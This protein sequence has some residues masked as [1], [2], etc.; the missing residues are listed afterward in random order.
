[1]MAAPTFSQ[2]KARVSTVRKKSSTEARFIGLSSP[3]RWT[4][5]REKRDGDLLY[6]IEQCDSPLAVRLAM[7]EDPGPNAVKV[8]VT[9]L[10][11][12]DLGDDVLIRLAKRRLIPF[13]SWRVVKTLFQAHAIDPRLAKHRWIAELLMECAARDDDRPAASGG[14]LDAET[15]WPL[16]LKHALGF[17]DG[18]PDLTSILRWSIE[19]EAAERYRATSA[20][21]KEGASSWLSEV[22][23][24]TARAVLNAIESNPKPDALPIGLA[25]GVVYHPKAAG[26][27]EKAAGKMEERHLGGTTPDERTVERWSAAANE[28]TRLQITDPRT[29]RAILDRADEILSEIGAESFAFLSSASPLGFDQR[30]A[31]FGALLSNL[32]KS[33]RY[34]AVE[35][36]VDAR[37]EVGDHENATRERVR[38][39]RLDMAIRLV[40]WLASR[41]DQTEGPAHSFVDAALDQVQ[42]AGFVDWARRAL[43]GGDSTRALSEAYAQLSDRVAVIREGQAK[44]FAEL[45]RRW[46]AEDHES[47][48]VVPVERFIED[49]ARPLAEA[50]PILLVVVDGM[51]VGVCRELLAEIVGH[52]WFPLSRQGRHGA[53]SAGLAALPSVTE[54]S[55]TSLFCGTLRRGAS[56]DE[57]A[58]FSTHPALKAACRGGP[59]PILFHKA[60]LRGVDDA[61]L[62]SD[63]RTEIASPRRI[64]GVVINAVDDML[65]KGEQVG[66]RWSR[67]SIPVLAALLH[68]AKAAKRLV[69]MTSDHGHIIDAGGQFFSHE[70]G[71]RWRVASGEPTELELAF[72]GRRVVIPESKALIAP[73]SENVR[74]GSKGYGYHG[75]ASPQEMITPIVVLSSTDAEIDGWMDA[76]SD[77]PV[78]WDESPSP[79][80]SAPSPAASRAKPPGKKTEWT[81]S[82][83]D[84]DQATDQASSPPPEPAWIAELFNSPIFEQQKKLAGR[85][86]PPDEVLRS[87]LGALDARGGKMTSPAIS[88]TINYPATRIRGLLATAQR[89]LNLDGFAVLARDD[90]SDTVELNRE[91]LRRQFELGSDHP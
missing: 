13:D 36:L 80:L 81:P 7:R 78:W 62:S 9:S 48:A 57:K 12:K 79:L 71:E 21:F 35:P 47:E 64:V 2:I 39:E 77:Q 59:P 30:L 22:A 87:L 49:V 45:L 31:E 90:A 15:A 37:R 75:G 83:F 61:V 34:D 8:L 25:L 4:G 5:E 16:L 55:R 3:G 33:E 76:P 10:D 60:A 82:L 32:V 85:A 28:A 53:V 20:E 18:R 43:R 68:E 27:L 66:H 67:D 70:G 88:R 86:V 41:R 46:T 51:S 19:P 38:L 63:V 89:L 17:Q 29:K 44:S 72:S 91:L 65:A 73:W 58:V 26:K 23:G 54:V 56:N 84:L 50:R 42:E 74:Y 1:M 69:V 24:P 14:F 11:E 40:R 6:I 52:E